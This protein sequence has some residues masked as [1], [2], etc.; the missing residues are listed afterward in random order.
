VLIP[1]LQG[2]IVFFAKEHISSVF[3]TFS[4]PE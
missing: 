2:Q 1:M 4:G 3:H